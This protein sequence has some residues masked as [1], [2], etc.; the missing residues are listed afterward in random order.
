MLHKNIVLNGLSLCVVSILLLLPVQVQAQQ[1]D[2]IPEM[3]TKLFHPDFATYT[4][5]SADL[6]EGQKQERFKTAMPQGDGVLA[7]GE[8]VRLKGVAP[9]FM[10]SRL[11]RRGREVWTK[12]LS[13]GGLS[14]VV[15]VLPY[16]KKDADGEQGFVLLANMSKAG[17]RPYFWIGFFDARGK[18]FRE[19]SIKDKKFGLAASDIQFSVGGDEIVVSVSAMIS[20][21]EGT[22]KT[23]RQNSV[24][25]T[26]DDKGKEISS[27]AFIL[28]DKS[29]ISSLSVLKS[30]GGE[31]G[32]IAT[33]WFENDFGKRNGWLLRLKGNLSMVWQKEFSRGKSAMLSKSIIDKN[34]YYVAVGGVDPVGDGAKAV[35]VVSVKPDN[36][37]LIWQRFYYG[38][39]GAH[40]YSPIGLIG[41]TSVITVA[42]QSTYAGE[43]KESSVVPEDGGGEVDVIADD[44]DYV[45]FLTLNTRGVTLSGDSYMTGYGVNVFDVSPIYNGRILMSG[46]TRVPAEDIFKKAARSKES[47]NPPLQEPSVSVTLPEVNMSDKAKAGLAKLRQNIKKQG[48]GGDENSKGANQIIDSAKSIELT[49]NGWIGIADAPNAYNDPCFK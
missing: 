42:M 32:Y 48:H 47:A 19:N 2:V 43:K 44:I 35:W 23:T 5:W 3:V 22:L 12:Y 11:D 29:H 25:Y 20:V 4:V 1:C 17:E 30:D 26:L 13:L 10:I 36:G 7:V 45:H 37:D 15:K 39:T 38:E 28:G 21:G 49:D 8:M 16:G 40:D 18:L 34:G 33:G 41:G 9:T 46:V 27:R 6:G 31:R 24:I 14:E